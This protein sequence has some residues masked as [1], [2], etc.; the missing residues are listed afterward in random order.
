MVKGTPIIFTGSDQ[1][2]NGAW[3]WFQDERAIVNAAHPDGPLLLFTAISASETRP[4]ESGDLDLHWLSLN[5]REQGM[6]ELHDTL[7]QDDHN[8]AALYALEDGRVLASYAKHGSDRMVRTRI[9]GVNDP[10]SWTEPTLYSEEA[11]VTYNNLLTV[12]PDRTLLNFS[13]SRGWNPNFLKFNQE[14][15]TWTYGG[16]LLTSEGRPY[17]KYRNTLDGMRIH[18]VATDQHPR[19]YDNSIYHGT[20][21]GASLL[22]SYGNVVDADLG[23]QDAAEPSDMTVVFVGDADNVAWIS[24][25]LLFLFRRMDVA[26]S[27]VMAVSIIAITWPDSRMGYGS[28]MRLPMPESVYTVSKM[29]TQAW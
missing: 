28:S 1:S 15:Q 9:S 5:S 25:S 21:D 19:D 14:T 12:G 18:V 17:M 7:Q 3:C 20:I 6:V 23:D 22:D 16:R 29:T 13:R 2:P 4:S 26:W 11:G 10:T 8:V 24:P 27:L